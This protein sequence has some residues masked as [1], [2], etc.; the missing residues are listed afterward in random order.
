M[1]KTLHV[2]TEPTWRGGEVQTLLLARGLDAQGHTADIV[3]PPGTPLAEKAREAGLTVF[4]MPMRGEADLIAAFKLRR[5]LKK[6][7]YQ[8]IHAHTSHA[9]TLCVMAAFGLKAR[10]IIARRVDFS[11][12]RHSFFHLNAIK[13]KYGLDRIITVSHAIRNV[14]LTD[15]IPDTR[16]RVVHSGIDPD[17]FPPEDFQAPR[18]P[19]LDIP[20][21]ALMVVNTAHLTPHKGQIHLIRA[22]PAI[23]KSVPKAFLLIAGQGELHDSLKAEVDRLG[24]SDRVLMPG[25]RHDIGAI[26]NNTDVY[27][28]P[29]IEEGLGTA[30]LDAF[31]FSLPVVGTRAGGIPEMITHEENG[32]LV[33]PAQPEPLAEAIITLLTQPALRKQLGQAARKTLDAHFTCHHTVQKTLA[34]YKEVLG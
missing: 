11:I 12:F 22:M 1:F 29:S 18:P 17:R 15:G 7:G 34:V 2:N 25:F 5:R 14:L 9:H 26:L 19:D 4:P 20:A 21:D 33:E 3:C 24:L 30:V 13:Y 23:L 6:G 10:V 32:L 16:I 27:V 8:L 31:T 28:M